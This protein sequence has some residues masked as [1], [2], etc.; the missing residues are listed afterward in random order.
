MNIPDL[1]QVSD[2][3]VAYERAV[4]DYYHH[5]PRAP[6]ELSSL[7]I[8][9][10]R[11][12]LITRLQKQLAYREYWRGKGRGLLRF[13]PTVERLK[14]IPL[15][16]KAT[17]LWN[18]GM[19][20]AL[21][22]RVVER[23]LCLPE[24]PAALDGFRILH[25]SDLHL[26]FHPD[27]AVRLAAVVAPLQVDVCMITGDFRH[28][29][30]GPHEPVLA[31]M[32]PLMQALSA[33]VYGILGNHDPLEILQPLE[34]MGITMLMNEGLHV[35]EGARSFFLAGVDDPHYYRAHDLGK[36]SADAGDGFRI[37]LSHSTEPFREARD[38]G[39]HVMLS[40]HTHGGQICLPAGLFR[41]NNARSPRH[42][43]QGHWS[44]GSLQ[45][46]TSSG[47]GCVGV[48]VRFNCPA[49]VVI[50]TLRGIA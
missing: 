21:D 23:E 26:D 32:E 10:G 17:F 13:G 18:R 20:N 2:P 37:L 3:Y 11:D 25:L 8:R 30:Y 47:A 46:Y 4:L 29:T 39:Y 33:P 50:Q 28:M 22:V 44:A 9:I 6:S 24:L 36:A 38:L 34:E 19:R 16:L 42:M 12:A 1:H 27:F 48:P 7:E 41:L 43:V 15:V 35:G 31:A 14:L 40:G 5:F 49:E 45:G